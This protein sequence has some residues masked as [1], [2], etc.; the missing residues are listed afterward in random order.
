MIIPVVLAGGVG[1][2]LWPVSRQLYP[3]QF[4]ALS[5]SARSSSARPSGTSES[6][7]T[8]N[9]D[10]TLFQATLT[11]LVGLPELGAPIVVCNEDHRFLTAQQL[12]ELGIKGAHIVLEPVGRNTA[13]A[14]AIAAL[15][16][17]QEDPEAILLVLP[18]DH[19]IRNTVVLRQVIE[20]GAELAAAGRLVTFGIV[21]AAPE[22]GYGYILRGE[23]RSGTAFA[24]QRF[25]E[26]VAR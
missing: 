19:A 18:A 25:V 1:T 10:D 20:H 11:R 21:P 26:S 9:S 8:D 17:L 5:S 22:T 15:Q 14:V 23:P 6:P 24:V 16:A 4:A 13:P 12:Q 7:S 2:R 3:K